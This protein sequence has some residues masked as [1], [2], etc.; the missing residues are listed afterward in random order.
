MVGKKNNTIAIIIPHA[1]R[2]ENLYK[3]F[4]SLVNLSPMAKQIIVSDWSQE[5]LDIK[6][7]NSY[8]KKIPLTFVH[9]NGVFDR[10][11]AINT[12]RKH[13]KDCPILL[14]I[15][16]DMWIP[17]NSIEVLQQAF[18]PKK[19]TVPKKLLVGFPGMKYTKTGKVIKNTA[20][21]GRVYG[22]FCACRVCDFDEV[23][24]YNILMKG[25]GYKDNDFRKRMLAIQGMEEIV[26]PYKYYHYWHKPTDN[27]ETDSQNRKISERSYFDGV[28]WRL[29]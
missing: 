20:T 19:T 6:K 3:C 16:A 29:R 22:G 4:D 24:G 7:I 17:P 10:A 12:A 28:K 5:E 14:L 23:G 11:P 2:F 8:A 26:L 27:R 25:W 15:D 13:I 9:Y 18:Y 21:F 1:D